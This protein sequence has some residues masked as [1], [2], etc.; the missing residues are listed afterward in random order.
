MLSREVMGVVALAILWVHTALIAAAAYKQRRSLTELASGL[1][2]KRG[3]VA[4]GEGPSGHLAAFEV[5]QVGRLVEGDAPAVVFHDQAHACRVFGGRVALHDGQYAEVTAS[6][7]AEVWVDDAMFRE[8]AECPEGG[9]FD[10]ATLDAKKARGFT[11]VVV[12][13]VGP[14]R[15]V[16][17]A[18][19]AKG[20]P[21]ERDLVATFDPR[22]WLGRRMALAAAFI[23]VEL[24]VAATCTGACLW[25]PAFGTV[26]KV[27]AGASLAFFLL[28][29]PAGTWL[30]GRLRVP[31]QAIRR[32]TWTRPS[33]D[34]VGSTSS[35]AP[36]RAERAESERG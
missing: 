34:R 23:L 10:A 32:G 16:F 12:A 35:G 5:T 4:S 17:L 1:T 15:E 8:A 30:R 18:T 19:V 28:V 26:S 22:A 29:Q 24:L 21:D 13:P 25:P 2:V 3:K 9:A 31:S 27:G 6:D 20:T 33:S 36:A 7:R 14:G 11:R